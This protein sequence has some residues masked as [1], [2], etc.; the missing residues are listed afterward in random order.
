MKKEKPSIEINLDTLA[1]LSKLLKRKKSRQFYADRLG[2]SVESV[3]RHIKEIRKIKKKEFK[4]TYSKKEDLIKGT[5]NSVV[6]VQKEPNSHKELAIVHNI[7]L[8]VFDITNYWSKSQSDGTFTSSVFCRR[9]QSKNYSI[10]DFT[11]FGLYLCR[12]VYV[13]IFIIN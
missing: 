13:P 2:I 10:K 7:D 1:V 5:L 8:S 11:S 12:I 9:K 6:N 4:E 3:E